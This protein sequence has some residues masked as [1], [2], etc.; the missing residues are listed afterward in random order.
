MMWQRYSYLIELREVLVQG[1]S[2]DPITRMRSNA[3]TGNMVGMAFFRQQQDPSRPVGVI[4]VSIGNSSRWR[5]ARQG[6]RQPC[7]VRVRQP[8]AP[9]RAG[10]RGDGALSEDGFL[11]VMRNAGDVHR[12]ISWDAGGAS[13]CRGRWR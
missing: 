9:L 12:L 8:L 2:Y 10:G 7:A 11:L 3:E 13:G 5:I 6:G 4:A 1:P